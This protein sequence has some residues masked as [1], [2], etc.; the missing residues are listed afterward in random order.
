L[1]NWKNPAK[2]VF[3]FHNCIQAGKDSADRE[4]MEKCARRGLL[5]AACVVLAATAVNAQMSHDEDIKAKVMALERVVR[6]QACEQKDLKTL[7]SVLDD[8]F[9]RV[10]ANGD[11]ENK[12]EFLAYIDAV[13]ALKSSAAEMTVKVHGD[14]AIVTGTFQ[15]SGILHGKLFLYRGR[16]IDTWILKEGQWLAVASVAAPAL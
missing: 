13:D 14:T 1:R 16:F 9:V 12:T 2:R 6:S 10:N 5:A 11:M 8:G 4:G 3:R 7:Q 15:S